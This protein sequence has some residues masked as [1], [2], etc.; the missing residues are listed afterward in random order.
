MPRGPRTRWWG[1][2]LLCAMR[3]DYLGFVTQLQR[4]H[5]DL[6]RMRLGYEDA[7]DV[8]H[9]ELVREA[10]VTHADQLI[11]WERGM[12]VFEEVFGQSVLVTEGPCALASTLRCWR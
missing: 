1:L 4:E 8:M 6:T 2:P 3:A 12:E 7:W 9:P 10:L 11:R 5:G